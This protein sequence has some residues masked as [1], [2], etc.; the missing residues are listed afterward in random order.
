[1][2]P[3]EERRVLADAG[4][5]SEG[6]LPEAGPGAAQPERRRRRGQ[7]RCR[8]RGRA[9]GPG[10]AGRALGR[11]AARPRRARLERRSERSFDAAKHEVVHEARIAKADLELR[12]MRVDIDA[13]RIEREEQH[14]RR[15][16]RLVEHVLIPEP[17]GVPQ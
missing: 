3:G 6:A 2:E 10:G 1:M 17:C 5:E 7:A 13:A 8:P 14:E 16:P 12:R 11:E 4:R 15:L 9:A